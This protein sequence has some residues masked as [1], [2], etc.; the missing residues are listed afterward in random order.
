MALGVS[1]FPDSVDAQ[2]GFG[3]DL[4]AVD[5]DPEDGAPAGPF[6][7][8][9]LTRPTT[10]SFVGDYERDSLDQCGPDGT[11]D[12][13]NDDAPDDTVADDGCPAVGLIGAIQQCARMNTDTGNITDAD[14]EGVDSIS[15][16]VVADNIKEPNSVSDG[17]GA[18]LTY[19]HPGGV[20]AGFQS[21]YADMLVGQAGGS[22]PA[23]AGDAN[24]DNDGAFQ[25]SVAQPRLGYD[26]E[27]GDGPLFRLNVTSPGAEIHAGVYP[28]KLSNV[29][30]FP[31]WGGAV[32]PAQLQ[33]GML[34]VN[35]DCPS[36]V[37][38]DLIADPLDNCPTVPNEGQENAD[39]DGFGDACDVCPTVS[40]SDTP[41][42]CPPP[43]PPAAVGGVVGLVDDGEAVESERGVTQE[44][45][46]VS[47]VGV[48]GLVGL[49]ASGLLVLRRQRR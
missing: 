11:G 12:G 49:L 23:N 33:H 44:R 18:R 17:Y 10:P 42:G 9:N 26:D 36:D 35:Q 13:V 27:W 22:Y 37:D 25:Q 46:L 16:D 19:P 32:V 45:S 43:G 1:E 24:G 34:A 15:V 4:V 8:T 48:V 2:A 40:G 20:I 28:M 38:E 6:S 39:A 5:M 47:L 21:S 29:R 14:E 41:Q 30:I 7:P 3:P 31:V